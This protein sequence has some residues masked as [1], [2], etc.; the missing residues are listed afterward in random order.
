MGDLAEMLADRASVVAPQLLGWELRVGTRAGTIVEVEAYEGAADGASH[1]ARGPTARNQL[2]F[3]RAGTLYVYL[4]Y[5]MHWCANIVCG[6]EGEPGAVL[7]RAIEPTDGLA[8]MWGDRPKATRETDLTSG[9]GKLCAALAISGEHNGVDLLSGDGPVRLLAPRV[10][11]GSDRW[12][13]GPRVG[14]TKAVDYRW[15]FAVR[16]NS[17]VSRPRP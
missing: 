2:M 13:N 12:L 14:I 8:E 10:G 6:A 17:Y 11:L 7:L 16:S 5:G 4:I 15:R 9:P 1:A 3:G